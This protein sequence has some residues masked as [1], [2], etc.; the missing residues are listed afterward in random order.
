MKGCKQVEQLTSRL[1]NI[2]PGRSSTQDICDFLALERATL[3][4]AFVEDI[5][6]WARAA[7]KAVEAC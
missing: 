5:L 1:V 6:V 7:F 2:L 3:V 4:V